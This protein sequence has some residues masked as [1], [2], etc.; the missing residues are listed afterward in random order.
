VAGL[1]CAPLAAYAAVQL[2]SAPAAF[3][4]DLRFVLG[5][6]AATPLAAQPALL[7]ENLVTL[8]RQDGLW[9]L[10]ALGLV[11]LRP[12]G[13]RW[14]ALILGGGA[15]V[16]IGRATPLFSL[17]FYYLIP[18]L[19]LAPL[20]LVGLA[21]RAPER[22]AARCALGA[23]AVLVA[24]GAAGVAQLPRGAEGMATPLD[25]FLVAPADGQAAAA[26]LAGARRPE[27]LV[28]AS[29]G[30]AW[31]LPGEVADVQMALAYAGQATPHV[32]AGVAA[33]RWVY[34]PSFA[35]ARYV[36]VDNLWRNWAV[37]NVSGAAAVLAEAETW[38]EVFRAGAVVV[39]E[40]PVGA[41]GN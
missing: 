27:E 12:R 28:L 25:E 8:V 31:R 36:V 13:L 15:F 3:W 20:G 2:L 6:T 18:L 11:A 33:E 24:L 19:P 9:A 23:L 34:D 41:P 32:P 17:S 21:A 1:A 22:W 10:G 29:P 37:Y 7:W 16:L 38:P 5:R 35:R 40:R 26:F 30:L 4:F 39:Y 14:A